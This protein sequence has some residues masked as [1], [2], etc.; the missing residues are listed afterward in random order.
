VKYAT[1]GHQYIVLIKKH[2]IIDKYPGLMD[3][4]YKQTNKQTK[5]EK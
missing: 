3:R 2:S 4:F 1:G 5:E